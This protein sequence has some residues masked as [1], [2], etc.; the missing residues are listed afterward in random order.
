MKVDSEIARHARSYDTGQTIDDLAHVEALVAAT[1]HAS[2]SSARDRLRLTN[3]SA[4]NQVSL[5]AELV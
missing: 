3:P 4:R 2:P 5:A 1:H